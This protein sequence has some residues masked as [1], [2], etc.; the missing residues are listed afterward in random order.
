MEF[1]NLHKFRE[2]FEIHIVHFLKIS[3]SAQMLDVKQYWD[4]PTFSDVTV[5]L[6]KDDDGSPTKTLGLSLLSSPS[7]P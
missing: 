4:S 2:L 1:W 3:H 6:E 7:F 5:V